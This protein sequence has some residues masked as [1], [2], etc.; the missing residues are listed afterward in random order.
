MGFV[1]RRTLE[2]LS[3]M[4]RLVVRNPEEESRGSPGRVRNLTDIPCSQ[5]LVRWPRGGWVLSAC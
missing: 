5:V 4:Q 1:R 2:H 3:V